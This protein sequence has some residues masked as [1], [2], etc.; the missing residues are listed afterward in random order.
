MPTGIRR[1]RPLTGRSH[2]A[3]NKMSHDPAEYQ[4]AT[5]P[6]AAPENGQPGASG[7]A[8][9]QHL[10]EMQRIYSNAVR[11]RDAWNCWAVRLASTLGISCAG[12]RSVVVSD[13]YAELRDRI[14]ASLPNE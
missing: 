12:F 13:Q 2:A 1:A 6:A 11:E 14:L 4:L 5:A 10:A 7:S 3:T 8:M 9:E